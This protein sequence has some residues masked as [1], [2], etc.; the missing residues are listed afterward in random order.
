ML[1]FIC[2]VFFLK[3]ISSLRAL[4]P[5]CLPSDV[6]SASRFSSFLELCRRK[7]FS[8]P[9]NAVWWCWLPSF[10]GRV[11]ECLIV[12]S[13]HQNHSAQQWHAPASGVKCS[14]CWAA[15]AQ[16]RTSLGPGR[17]SCKH[18]ASCAREGP[19]LM[20]YRQWAL[21]FQ[22]WLRPHHRSYLVSITFYDL[23][24]LPLIFTGLSWA[25]LPVSLP[26]F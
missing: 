5:A 14:S 6:L 26:L 19:A 9:T 22:T 16:L 25:S 17:E 21:T 24:F 7:H 23:R 8:F 13:L 20:V 18:T 3:E 10:L 11:P 2:G 1:N 15:E 4:L 12:Q